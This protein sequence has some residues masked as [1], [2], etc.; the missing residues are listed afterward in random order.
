MNVR[1]KFASPNFRRRLIIYSRFGTAVRTSGK[2][3]RFFAEYI[4]G[5]STNVKWV[6]LFWS[7]RTDYVKLIESF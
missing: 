7:V 4:I 1:A 5:S 3:Y 2:T 6:E